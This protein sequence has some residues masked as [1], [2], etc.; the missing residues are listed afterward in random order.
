MKQKMPTLEEL[1][2]RLGVNYDSIAYG[3]SRALLNHTHKPVLAYAFGMGSFIA[4]FEIRYGFPRAVGFSGKQMFSEYPDAGYYHIDPLSALELIKDN[5]LCEKGIDEERLMK[6]LSKEGFEKPIVGQALIMNPENT[7]GSL[8]EIREQKN[9][10][11]IVHQKY[12]RPDS[13]GVSKYRSKVSLNY[14]MREYVKA[15]QKQKDEYGH[16]K[17]LKEDTIT[18]ERIKKLESQ[19]IAQTINEE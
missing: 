16:Y 3:E 17:I 13:Y 18:P 19:F 1:R 10:K 7:W 8:Y 11:L 2:N 15:K 14:F 5:K 12:V 9:G 4:I 6:A